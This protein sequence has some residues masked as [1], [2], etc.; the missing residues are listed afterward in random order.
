MNTSI[1][2][3][4]ANAQLSFAALSLAVMICQLGLPSCLWRKIS[5]IEKNQLIFYFVAAL[6]F[7]MYEEE[8][9]EESSWTSKVG[10]FSLLTRLSKKHC[11]FEPL[12]DFLIYYPIWGLNL[13]S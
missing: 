7:G 13:Q 8:E 6:T 1:F 5:F 2:S 12:L 10:Y 11:S 4:Q 3:S 9:E